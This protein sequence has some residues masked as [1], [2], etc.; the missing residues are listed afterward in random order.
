VPRVSVILP[1]RNA[2]DWLAECIAS[3]DAQTFREFE[4]VAVNDRSTDGTAGLLAEWATRDRRVRVFTID[5]GG[6]AATAS[7]AAAEGLVAA[8]QLAASASRAPLLA[9]MDA[10]DVAH[11]ERLE[12]QVRY[13]ADHPELAACGTGVELFPDRSVGEGYR[14][15]EEWLNSLTDPERVRRDLFVECPL[16]HPTMVIR[17]S[18]MRGLGGYRDTGWPEDY[19]LLLRLYAAGMSASNL[20]GKLLRWRVR[21]DRHSL[22][23]DRYSAAAFRRCKVHFLR[24]AFLPAS[25]PLV[26]WG[27]GKV[28]KPLALELRRQGVPVTAFV[29]LD[30]RKIGQ[31]IH[32]APV[33]DPGGFESRLREDR[34][35]VLGAVGSAGARSRIRDAL[36]GLG[37][38]EI[39]DYRMCA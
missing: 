38:A 18:V 15:Y 37:C 10:D 3:L 17:R 21:E 13:L 22:A 34:P 36:G 33:L 39:R 11:P 12:R 4:V 25:R 27:A 19:D 32:G 35:Y 31:E 29:D 24:E 1:C 5:G 6:A 30:P 14:R 23:S 8:L 2:A 9:R 28:G 26:V 7:G 16:A 20:D